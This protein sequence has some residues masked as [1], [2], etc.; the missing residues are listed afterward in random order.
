MAYAAGGMVLPIE[1][2]KYFGAFF[3]SWHNWKLVIV[4]N[5]GALKFPIENHEIV[6]HSSRA[7]QKNARKR[8]GASSL[9]KRIY[10]WEKSLL[11]TYLISS[12]PRGPKCF[13]VHIIV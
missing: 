13:F 9:I 11:R 8:D 7:A 3:F 12:T 1:A 5:D 6:W 2:A 10:S 4:C